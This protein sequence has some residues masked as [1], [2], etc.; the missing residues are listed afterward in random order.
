[1]KIFSLIAVL[2]FSVTISGCGTIGCR[3]DFK[4]NSFIP[5]QPN[6]KYTKV[7]PATALDCVNIYGAPFPV[8]VWYFIDTPISLITDTILLPFDLI[9]W[10]SD[11]TDPQHYG[12]LGI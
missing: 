12:H 9:I 5:W 6:G 8:N 7:Y 4:P 11:D 10:R 1:M 3:N 2:A